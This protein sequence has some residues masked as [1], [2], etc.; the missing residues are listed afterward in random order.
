MKF[1]GKITG[2]NADYYIAETPAESDEAELPP[3]VEPKGTGVNK[4]T[5]WVCNDLSSDW[6]E[7]PIVTPEQIVVSRKIK[8]CFSGDLNRQIYAN[9]HF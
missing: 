6:Q 5:Y 4:M 1:W 8:Y 3:E 9:P 7:L 2:T